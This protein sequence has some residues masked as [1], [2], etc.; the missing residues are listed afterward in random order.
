MATIAQNLQSLIDDRI[1][2]AN[3]ISDKGVTVPTGSGYNDF[4]SL[5]ASIQSG[6]NIQQ[7]E[8]YGVNIYP[9]TEYSTIY[10][11]NN[12]IFVCAKF[13]IDENLSIRKNSPLIDISV[14]VDNNVTLSNTFTIDGVFTCYDSS[15]IS[16]FVYPLILS[17]FSISKYNN[18]LILRLTL[19][20]IDEGFINL[21][22]TYGF[23]I[24]MKVSI[25]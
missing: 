22:S 15:A 5:I 17:N 13:V 12:K 21:R 1:S 2:I 6:T 14:P 25:S 20:P 23:Y 18:N 24:T 4:A 8:I 16:H 7:G 11:D 9:T 10:Y 19:D 3:A